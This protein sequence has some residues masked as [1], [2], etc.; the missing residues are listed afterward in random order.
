MKAPS[1]LTAARLEE[2]VHRHQR[3]VRG[4]LLFLGCPPSAVDDL[5]QEVFLA[6]F[7][8]G[9]EDRGDARAGAY[10]RQVAR[11]LFLKSLRGAERRPRML[12]LEEAERAWVRYEADDGGERY[13]AALRRCLE[14]VEGRPLEVLTLRYRANLARAAIAERLGLSESGVKSILVRT[15]ERLRDCVERSLER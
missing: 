13:L 4:F 7:A 12:G 5:V 9:F 6:V 3:S 11:N 10:L 1:L 2:L 14:K 15:R 8:A